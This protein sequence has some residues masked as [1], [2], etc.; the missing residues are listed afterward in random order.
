[1]EVLP[2]LESP[3]VTILLVFIWK[4]WSGIRGQRDAFVSKCRLVGF[5][6]INADYIVWCS[7][8]NGI[9][10]RLQAYLYYYSA[11]QSYHLKQTHTVNIN[12]NMTHLITLTL[13]IIVIIKIYLNS[14]FNFNKTRL[15]GVGTRTEQGKKA[16]TQ[17]GRSNMEQPVQR[18]RLQLLWCPSQL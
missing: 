8:F 16:K 10:I 18:I 1:M 9:V 14:Y 13:I 11:A 5:Q 17:D 4:G 2:V 7:V 6:D 12:N 15:Q 3:I